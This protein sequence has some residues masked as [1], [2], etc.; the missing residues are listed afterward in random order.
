MRVGQVVN[1][2]HF[3]LRNG[4]CGRS[5]DDGLALVILDQ[6]AG[7]VG[8]GVDMDDPRRFHEGKLVGLYPFVAGKHDRVRA[9]RGVRRGHCRRFAGAEN[10]GDAAQLAQVTQGLAGRQAPGDIDNGIFAHAVN[11]EVGL[12]VE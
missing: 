4:E 9:P 2:V 7:V 5:D 12:G 6:C 1:F 11:D 3:L 10:V 8:V